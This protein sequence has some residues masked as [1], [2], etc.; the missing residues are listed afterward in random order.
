MRGAEGGE[1]GDGVWSSVALGDAVVQMEVAAAVAAFSRGKKRRA[2]A[3]V[4][5]SHRMD[6][7]GGD[8]LGNSP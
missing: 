5:Q 1:I 2:A 8:F 4:A 7:G 6:D 3:L